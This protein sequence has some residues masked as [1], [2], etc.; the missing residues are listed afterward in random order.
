MSVTVDAV[1]TY[2]SML[3]EL[4]PG[5]SLSYFAGL[6][7]EAPGALDATARNIENGLAK[8]PPGLIVDLGCGHGLQAYAFN[9]NGRE[10]LGIDQKTDR[11]DWA[12]QAVERLG[13]QGITFEIGDATTALTG[14]KVGAVWMHRSIHHLPDLPAFIRSARDALEPAGALVFVTSNATSRRLLGFLPFVRP[15]RHSVHDLR[16]D[17]L[18]GGFVIESIEYYGFLTSLPGHL[19]PSFTASADRLLARIPGLR[20]LAGSLTV[21]ARPM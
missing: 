2:L 20:A 10:V 3:E 18:A 5:K 4:R 11:V 17:L 19:R 14:R 8:F 15:G 7:E 6:R 12:N 13:A 21:T 16:R 1:R 9:A